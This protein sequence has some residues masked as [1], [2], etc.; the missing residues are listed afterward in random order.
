MRCE[1][2]P[3]LGFV[4]AELVPLVS[5]SRTGSF[6][7]G[8]G[9]RLMQDGKLGHGFHRIDPPASSWE[10]SRRIRDGSLY[11][12]EITNF[13]QGSRSFRQISSSP[14]EQISKRSTSPPISFKINVLALTA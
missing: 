10:I 6:F 1:D 3:D 5:R 13:S 2:A 4:Q 12:P 7:F 11:T 9:R 14:G 8:F